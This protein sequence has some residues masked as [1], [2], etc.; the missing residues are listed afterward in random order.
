MK[1]ILFLTAILITFNNIISLVPDAG[2][3]SINSKRLMQTV[4]T[5]CSEEF[6]GRLSGSEGYIKAA[7]FVAGRFQQIGLLPAGDD[8]FF[9]YLNVEYNKIDAPVAF[10]VVTSQESISY[11]LGKDFVFRGFTGSGNLTLPVA[12]CGYGISRPDLGYDDY[13]NVNVQ[14]NIVIVFKQN[15]SW[16]ISD[17]L[18]EREYPREKSIIAYKH[19]ARG[20]LFVSRPNDEKPQPLI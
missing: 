11:E 15:P 12:F 17:E 20:I 1:T 9:Q 2:L 14:D 6:D 18:W 10:K 16:K 13:E 7:D 19:G 8:N 5:L 4:E 3:E